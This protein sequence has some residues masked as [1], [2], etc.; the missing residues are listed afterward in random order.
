MLG[1]ALQALGPRAPLFDGALD[2]AEP[3]LRIVLGPGR[4]AGQQSGD[5]GE[6]QDKVAND[7]L[8]G[9]G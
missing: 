5:G 8:L 2:V 9:A 6:C 3:A 1:F 4:G 7:S